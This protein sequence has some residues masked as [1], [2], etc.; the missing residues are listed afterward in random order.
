M[1]EMLGRF[2]ADLIGRLHG[3]LTFR[4]VVQ[5]LTACVIAT[6]DGCRDARDGKPAYLWSLL[7][8]PSH[9][10]ERIREGCT[11]IARLFGVGLFIDGVYQV[12]ALHWFYP[13]EAIVVACILAVVPYLLIRGPVNRLTRVTMISGTTPANNDSKRAAGGKSLS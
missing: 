6:R 9:R 1:D 4:L 10:R 8:D 12:I 7:S 13:G 3:P 11:S 5:P 2:A